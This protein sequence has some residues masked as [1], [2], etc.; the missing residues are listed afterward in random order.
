MCGYQTHEKGIYREAAER[1][2]GNSPPVFFGT[3]DE[4]KPSVST[5]ALNVNPLV[6]SWWWLSHRRGIVIGL[7]LGKGNLFGQG[8]GIVKGWRARGSGGVVRVNPRSYGVR[9]RRV[10]G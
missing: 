6:W 2:K 10:R 8:G 5:Y 7:Q 1:E 3:R 9:E 4:G